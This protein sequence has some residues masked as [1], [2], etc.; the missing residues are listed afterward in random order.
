[1]QEIYRI[2]IGIFVLGLGFPMGIFLS[3]IT[4]EELKENQFWF[5]LIII[6]SLIGAVITL[7]LRIDSLFFS[8][9]FLAIITSRSLKK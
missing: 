5:K 3:K 4:K 8:F 1:M 6:A 7:I 9:L 2:L